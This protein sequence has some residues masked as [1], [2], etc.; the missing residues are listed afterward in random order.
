MRS[1]L[2]E[3]EDGLALSSPVVHGV[4]Q[5]HATAIEGLANRCSIRAVPITRSCSL[6]CSMRRCARRTHIRAARREHGDARVHTALMTTFRS[7]S[8]QF[9]SVGRQQP[10]QLR[11]PGPETRHWLEL[12]LVRMHRLRP[13]NLANHLPR[14]VQLP[15]DRLDRLALYKKSPRR[16][17]AIVSQPAPR[18]RPP[19]TSRGSRPRRAESD[20]SVTGPRG[21]SLLRRDPVAGVLLLSGV[22][23]GPPPD[24]V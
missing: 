20:A 1:D 21:Q 22:G 10:I 2:R 3:T 24:G 16:I 18:N 6:S 15:A 11:A 14:D 17:R 9:A 5:R 23:A 13:Q 19:C 8:P 7:S 4:S 12:A